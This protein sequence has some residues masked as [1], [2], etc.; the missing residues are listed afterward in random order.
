MQCAWIIL[1]PSPLLPPPVH[2]KIVFHKTDVRCQKGEWALEHTHTPSETRTFY[3]LL[4]AKGSEETS[5]RGA[6]GS[7]SST[8][9]SGPPFSLTFP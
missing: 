2:G 3:F 4:N 9:A 7:S 6:V 1:K 5:V 8:Q